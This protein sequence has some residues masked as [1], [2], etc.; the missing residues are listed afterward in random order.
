MSGTQ[1]FHSYLN[2]KV[3]PCPGTVEYGCRGLKDGVPGQLSR[4]ITRWG[5]TASTILPKS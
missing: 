2:A 3:P 5:A 1:H 4:S